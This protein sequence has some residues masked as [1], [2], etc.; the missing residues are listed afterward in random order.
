[1]NRSLLRSDWSKMKTYFFG[2]LLFILFF[3]IGCTPIS[4]EKSCSSAADCVPASCCHARDA[5]NQEYKPDCSEALCTAVC[6]PGTLDCGQGEIECRKGAC[7]VV[8][9]E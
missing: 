4:P 7:A 1:M 5:V 3:I 6:E 8:V 9:T 2:L